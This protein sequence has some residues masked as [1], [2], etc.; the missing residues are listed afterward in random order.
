MQA[1][2]SSGKEVWTFLFLHTELWLLAN[3]KSTKLWWKLLVMTLD[4]CNTFTVTVTPQSVLWMCTGPY[5]I[6]RSGQ[7][8]KWKWYIDPMNLN[9][10]RTN[11]KK[12]TICLQE[13]SIFPYGVPLSPCSVS[14]QIPRVPHSLS[15]PGYDS[16]AYRSCSIWGHFC[17]RRDILLL[18]LR[19]I[20]VSKSAKLAI[21]MSLIW[22]LKYMRHVVCANFRIS[23]LVK[24]DIRKLV[25]FQSLRIC[26][27]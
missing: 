14:E 21:S 10:H 23:F 12:Q 22:F 1:K 11:E 7:N 17:V 4:S 24:P 2:L 13:S 9:L 25:L 27:Y 15:M 16:R 3:A 5:E 19:R 18:L 26:W 6:H 8:L 20:E